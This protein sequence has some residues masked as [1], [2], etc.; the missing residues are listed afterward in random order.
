M[1]EKTTCPF[2]KKFT[3]DDNLQMCKILQLF[4]NIK[5]KQIYEHQSWY[6]KTTCPFQKKFITDDYLQ[7]YKILQLF[8]NRFTLNTNKFTSIKVCMLKTTCQFQIKFLE[9]T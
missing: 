3:T 5:Y 8:T 4:T 2:Q 7:L 1:Y 9:E 6:E